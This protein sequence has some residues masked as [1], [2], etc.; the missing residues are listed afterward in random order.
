M[1]TFLLAMFCLTLSGCPSD[2]VC[3]F[4]CS[5]IKEKTW[6]VK[7]SIDVQPGA[8]ATSADVEVTITRPSYDDT[9]SYDGIPPDT[10]H[11][12]RRRVVT[13]RK[14][15]EGEWPYDE[16]IVLKLH[17]SCPTLEKSGKVEITIAKEA[18]TGKVKIDNLP[19]Q[20]LLVVYP[21]E[22]KRGLECILMTEDEK[23]AQ[24]EAEEAKQDKTP[25]DKDEEETDDE[26]KLDKYRGEQAFFIK[27]P[28]PEVKLSEVAVVPGSPD[29][30]A[31]IKVE[32]LRNDAAVVA[33][34]RSFELEVEVKLPWQCEGQGIASPL[35][36]GDAHLVI[37]AGESSAA[38]RLIMPPQHSVPLA[39]TLDAR[40]LIDSYIIGNNS[41]TLEI[42]I[43]NAG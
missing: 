39:C 33:G 26:E 8:R 30:Y 15:S 37:P 40:A 11:I 17:W 41:K 13:K 38:A 28:A 34:D 21:W 27:K 19:P 22:F 20:P 31:D 14:I 42:R 18:A 2:P 10:D 23:F 16:E 6:G 32:L 12:P 9:S 4:N 36:S 1:R 35:R 7:M 5:A 25:S 3:E 29:S 43:P 24:E